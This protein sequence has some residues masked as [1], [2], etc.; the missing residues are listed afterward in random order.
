MPCSRC[1]VEESTSMTSRRGAP[2]ATYGHS[3][4]DASGPVASGEQYNIEHGVECMWQRGDGNGAGGGALQPVFSV[5]F[6]PR[7]QRYDRDPSRCA[8]AGRGQFATTQ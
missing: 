2:I 6:D 1:V 3:T 5:R 4:A 7:A 8:V